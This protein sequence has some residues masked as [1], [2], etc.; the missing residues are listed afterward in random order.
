MQETTQSNPWTGGRAGGRCAFEGADEAKGR[1]TA[2]KNNCVFITQSLYIMAVWSQQTLH[3]PSNNLCVSATQ[4]QRMSA[5]VA[6][7]VAW[8]LCR[9]TRGGIISLASD[10]IQSQK[11]NLCR[12]LAAFHSAKRNGFQLCY[13]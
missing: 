13:D 3:L 12:F 8:A 7:V 2:A 11:Q 4:I 10:T 9:R 1:Q 5:F 6:V